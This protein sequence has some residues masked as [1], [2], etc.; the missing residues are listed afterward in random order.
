[1]KIRRILRLALLLL[2]IGS[3]TSSCGTIRTYGGIEHEYEYD[4][5]GHHHHKHKKHKKHK[6]HHKKHKHH[7]HHHDHDD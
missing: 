1:M 2:A 6:K 5:D 7:H 4:L 3:I